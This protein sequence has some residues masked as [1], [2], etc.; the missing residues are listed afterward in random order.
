MA[1]LGWKADVFSIARVPLPLVTAARVAAACGLPLFAGVLTGQAMAGVIAAATALLTTLADIGESRRA[2]SG[3]MA[4]AVVALLLGGAIG[5]RYGVTTFA[6]EVLIFVAAVLAGWVS[7]AHPGI[8]TVARFFAMAVAIGAG[9]HLSDPSMAWAAL[10]G[11]ACAIAVAFI[12]WRFDGVPVSE[13]LFDWR[14]GIRRA[15][16]GFGAGPLFAV[17]YGLAAVLA[18]MLAH[19]FGVERPYWAAVT[20]LM[21]M[22]REG[23][24]NLKLVIQYMTGTLGGILAAGAV[25]PLLNP[26]WALALVATTCAASARIGI[27]LNPALG[28]AG[29]TTFFM[30]A[31]DI[32]L[33]GT[34]M[35]AHILSTRLLDVGVGCLIALAWTLIARAIERAKTL[36]P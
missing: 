29:I 9:L 35:A 24:L 27:A 30:L 31:F 25:T 15:L 26:L 4:V 28:F 10:A 19:H 1:E 14:T 11:G 12:T 36:Q 5:G 23:L 2:R 3:T 32:A 34:G 6:D 16:L 33:R 22:R 17:C 8:S 18:L 7:A 21:V 13:N 20:V